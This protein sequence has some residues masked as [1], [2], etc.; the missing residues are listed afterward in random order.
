MYNTVFDGMQG[1]ACRAFAQTLHALVVPASLPVYL[2]GKLPAFRSWPLLIC[3]LRMSSLRP[4]ENCHG[5]TLQL[6]RL[7]NACTKLSASVHCIVTLFM[8]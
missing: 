7:A 1:R 2:F 8:S 4:N 6:Y 5:H 3:D